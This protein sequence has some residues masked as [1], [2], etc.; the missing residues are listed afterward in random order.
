MKFKVALLQKLP[1]PMNQEFNL[2]KGI[3]YCKTAKDMGAH[4]ALFP[5][6]WNIGYTECPFDREGRIGWE[7][8]AIDRQ[9]DFFHR[10]VEL[11]RRLQLHIALTYLEKY[12]PK[13]RNTVSI[14]NPQGEVILNYSKVYIC[15][16]GKEELTRE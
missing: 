13:P 7:N 12:Q 15:D 16:F 3:E 14:I 6:M 1:E 10:Y 2:Q 4:L 9:S 8:A 5:E 11:A